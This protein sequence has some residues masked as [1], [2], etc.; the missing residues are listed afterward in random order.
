MKATHAALWLCLLLSVGCAESTNQAAD[1]EKGDNKGIF[2]KKTQEIGQFDPNNPNQVVSDQKIRAR[3]PITGP[4][5]AYGPM[6]EKISKLGI[7]K[8]VSEFNAIEG[9]Y[10]KDYDEFMEKIIKANNI[11][12]PVLPYKGRYQYDEANHTLVIVRDPE[13]AKKAE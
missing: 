7:D 6:A 11:Q 3:D 8:A 5:A 2:G 12:L 9:R 13:D 4:L 1:D 10:P